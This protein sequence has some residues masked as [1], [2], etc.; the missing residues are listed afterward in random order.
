MTTLLLRQCLKVSYGAHLDLGL[1]AY[2]KS[3][4]KGSILDGV[5]GR[6]VSS[7]IGKSL[8]AK[9]LQVTVTKNEMVSFPPGNTN[10]Q[11]NS[12]VVFN[13]P[14]DDTYPYYIKI[15]N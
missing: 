15:I 12:D 11:P 9:K 5:I 10:S 1:S 3:K 4:D 8:A 14:Y 13:A 2:I 6:S 7:L